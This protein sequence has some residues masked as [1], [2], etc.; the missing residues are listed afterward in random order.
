MLNTEVIT[1]CYDD[2]RMAMAFAPLAIIHDKI[3]LDEPEV[4]KKSYPYFWK[5]ITSAG[6]ITAIE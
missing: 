6:F 3:R 2:H 4:V 1:K 5:D